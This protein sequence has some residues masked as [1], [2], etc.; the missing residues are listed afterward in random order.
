MPDKLLIDC[1][2]CQAQPVS[3]TESKV[4]STKT[5]D[6]CDGLIYSAIQ[7][8]AQG[9]IE[10][11]ADSICKQVVG[12]ESLD[13]F[14]ACVRDI[15]YLG[16]ESIGKDRRTIEHAIVD[17]LNRGMRI[18]K[19]LKITRESI[20]GALCQGAQEYDKLFEDEPSEKWNQIKRS[21]GIK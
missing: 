6:Y 20:Q 15:E 9:F 16:H 21:H 4:L 19:G 1:N 14:D 5:E 3:D 11:A 2:K 10:V 17:R 8:D 13:A 7:S 18:I 12:K